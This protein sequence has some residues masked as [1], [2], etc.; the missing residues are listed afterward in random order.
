MALLN[1]FIDFDPIVDRLWGLLKPSIE[2]QL[3][4]L[5]EQVVALIPVIGAAAA[6]AIAD[7]FPDLIRGILERDPDI[8]I[9]SDVFDLSEI[10]RGSINDSNIPIHIPGLEVL[11][12][13]FKGLD[14]R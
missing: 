11:G 10:L 3:D 8:P 4:K 1:Q 7:K 13:I 6:K 5:R 2:A 12:D 9:V 14:S